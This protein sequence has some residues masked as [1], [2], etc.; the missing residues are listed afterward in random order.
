MQDALGMITIKTTLNMSKTC[1]GTYRASAS[2]AVTMSFNLASPLWFRFDPRRLCDDQFRE[3]NEQTE[4]DPITNAERARGVFRR[5]R[6]HISLESGFLGLAM[7]AAARS[8]RRTFIKD[9][10]SRM[11]ELLGMRKELPAR[12][13]MPTLRTHKQ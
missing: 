9:L 13:D 4:R 5:N 2:R 10:R 12:R 11:H 3:E 7:S 8:E 6:Q 1:S